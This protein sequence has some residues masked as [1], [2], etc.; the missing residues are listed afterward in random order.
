M[1]AI[2]NV[3]QGRYLVTGKV[4]DG[5]MQSVFA[6]TDNLIGRR[7]AIKTPLPGQ[8]LRKFSN[9]AVIAARV[10]HSSVAKTYDYF[11][12]DHTPFLVEELVD[13]PNLEDVFPEGMFVDPHSGSRLLLS[14]SKGIAAS[15]AAGVVHRDLKPSNLV[16][17]KG[18]FL[19]TVKITDFGIATLTEETF[20]SEIVKGGDLTRSTSGTVKGAL[21]YM[22]PEMMFRK[23]GDH[24]GPEA[25][26]WSLGALMFKL[27]TGSYPFG[28]GF[29]V[30]VAI[31]MNTREPWPE[32]MVSNPQYAALSR[33][34]QTVVESCLVSDPAQRLP[35][36]ALTEA[37]ERLCFSAAPRQAGAVASRDG[38]KGRLQSDTGQTVF[39]HTESVYGSVSAKV[40][41]RMMFATFP[42][43]PHPR[44]H[45]VSALPPRA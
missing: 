45:P 9:S 28:T 39:F 2:G 40:G 5:G 42:G 10:N 36:A 34:L 21:P 24:P 37:C 38:G 8:V 16:T 7:V 43:V 35:I 1:I 6:A 29:D 4:G 3:L 14:L 44:A 33:E 41:E 15:H 12:Q 26:V 22:A 31:K 17:Q 25:D 13:G 30:P 32:F 27:L 19:N 20:E 11:E 23:A 18:S